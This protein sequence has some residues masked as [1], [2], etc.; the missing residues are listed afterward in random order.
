M[1]SK[2]FSQKEL[3][4]QCC[5]QSDISLNLLMRL[6]AT[7]DEM[8][9]P[10]IVNSAYRCKKHNAEIA[11]TKNSFHL[12]GKAIDIATSNLDGFKK[13]QL[14]KIA[15]NKGFTG[16]GV[17]SDENGK[18]FDADLRNPWSADKDGLHSNWDDLD[19]TDIGR[20]AS[21]VQSLAMSS[22]WESLALSSRWFCLWLI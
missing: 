8:Q 9:H 14:I 17:Y 12:E 16:I 4:C 21:H 6:Q 1:E 5:T 18:P 22:R 20:I 19:A 11:G 13:F 2:N 3:E 10:L 15:I 7:R